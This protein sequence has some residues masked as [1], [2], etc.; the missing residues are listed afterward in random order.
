MAKIDTSLENYTNAVDAMKNHQEANAAVFD[1]HKKLLM[2]TIDAENVLRDDAS[3]MTE[4]L[5]KDVPAVVASNAQFRVIVTR[6]TLKTYDEEKLRRA[7]ST[8]NPT[9]LSEAITETERPARI[10][11][12]AIAP[13]KEKGE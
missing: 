7:L 8:T 13:L 9:V 6:Q 3:T 2:A 5:K 1:A 4:G 12:S 11:I 10:I